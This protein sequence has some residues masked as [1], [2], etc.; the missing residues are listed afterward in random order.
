MK[1]KILVF[2][3]YGFWVCHT[4]FERI[5]SK[6]LI[7][8]GESVDFLYCDGVFQ[9][10]DLKKNCVICRASQIRIDGEMGIKAQP[11][12]KYLDNLSDR[13]VS[14]SI[15]D[16]NLLNFTRNGI[17]ISQVIESSFCSYFRK[18]F[19]AFDNPLQKQVYVQL[20]NSAMI[21][22]NCLENYYA[23]HKPDFGIIFSGRFFAVRMALEFFKSKNIEFITHELGV[24]SDSF[25]FNFDKNIFY[26]R[27]LLDD[28]EKIKSLPISKFELLD[29]IRTIR[30]WRLGKNRSGFVFIRPQKKTS[31][32]VALE[33][34]S[35]KYEKTFLFL[36][37]S[38]DEFVRLE[39]YDEH[40]ES[41]IEWLEQTIRYFKAHANYFCIIRVHPNTINKDGELETMLRFI[42]ASENAL[43]ENVVLI[44]P[45][46]MVNT[47]EMMRIS[48][49][50]VTY[51][52]TASMEMMAFKKRVLL[53][54]KCPFYFL[55]F[56]D[57]I[58]SKEEYFEKLDSLIETPLSWDELIQFYRF[59][60]FYIKERS[61]HFPYIRFLDNVTSFI[62]FNGY[63]NIMDKHFIDNILDKM[64]H[65]EQ[66]I[67]SPNQSTQNENEVST[68]EKL[69][70]RKKRLTQ[71]VVLAD[72]QSQDFKKNG[73]QTSALYEELILNHYAVPEIIFV[74]DSK[75][76]ETEFERLGGYM[77]YFSNVFKVYYRTLFR[78]PFLTFVNRF[79]RK[80][81]Y[82]VFKKYYSRNK[83]IKIMIDSHNPDYLISLLTKN[84]S[85][86]IHKY[87]SG[88]KIVFLKKDIRT[89]T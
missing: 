33:E 56:F 28:F 79:I 44:Q 81:F 88:R 21:A 15:A 52:S 39:D 60:F 77:G 19:V 25:M 46:E 70:F 40:F 73:D 67:I 12:S 3:P 26:F 72:I 55:P 62:N 32:T 31:L 6:R 2:S 17:N 27:H 89:S 36:T 35:K 38:T 8:K 71:V 42:R 76:I 51:G 74:N 9:N 41:Q 82:I 78:V 63:E 18:D 13:F 7:E 14:E 5:I 37:S 45:K 47:Y 20:L 53:V 75:W 34:K 43:P 50:A 87:A 86:E 1:R 68:L 16:K 4:L 64:F 80:T 11:M 49:V 59:M 65:R 58:E 61:F 66:K 30:G 10:C 83:I 24:Y 57:R 69:N 23:K 85:Q 84:N 29:T 48:N 22:Q 54:R